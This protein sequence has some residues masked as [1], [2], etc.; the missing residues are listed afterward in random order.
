MTGEE[1]S[2]GSGMRL[3]ELREEIGVSLVTPE[4]IRRLQRALYVKAKQEPT[5]RFHCLYDKVWRENIPA[6]AY[7]CCPADGGPPGADGETVARVDPDRGEQ[8]VGAHPGG[9]V[10]K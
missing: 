8:W 7:S 5:R 3:N 6:H 4:K 10:N 2:P 1:R 9:G